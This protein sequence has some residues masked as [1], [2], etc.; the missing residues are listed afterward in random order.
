MAYKIVYKKATCVV[1]ACMHIYNVYLI[2]LPRESLCS[3]LLALELHLN[4]ITK[5]GEKLTTYNEV[6]I[7]LDKQADILKEAVTTP[8]HPLITMQDK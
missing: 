3:V 8:N 1:N 5:I 7:K 4:E 6:T 2:A